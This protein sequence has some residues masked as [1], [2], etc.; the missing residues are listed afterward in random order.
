MKE[1]TVHHPLASLSDILGRDSS[2]FVSEVYGRR[3]LHL[4]KANA[5][6]F[7][8]LVTLDEIDN[9]L[10]SPSTRPP[11][12]RL[13]KQSRPT[14]PRNFTF[15]ATVARRQLDGLLDHA[16]VMNHFH[17]GYTVVLDSIEHWLPTV[18]SLLC[19][20][21]MELGA[22]GRA[23]VFASPPHEQALEPHADSYEIF[24]LQVSG[25]KKWSLY[26][27][28]DP[29]PRA[30]ARLNQDELGPKTESL[31]LNP[32]DVLYL[33]WGTPHVVE[34]LDSPSVHVSI[35]LRPP[36]WGEV[37]EELLRTVVNDGR[38][39]EPVL[40]HSGREDELSKQLST[41]LASI[42]DGVEAVSP[43]AY[44]KRLIATALESRRHSVG[45]TLA[46]LCAQSS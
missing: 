20:L 45:L 44:A 33:P 25:S 2:T 43:P 21:Q 23:A 10:A 46:S 12:I 6:A 41:R 40:M 4:P 24:V 3:P 42:M 14:D 30:G 11:Y 37:L 27:R 8:D 17:R 7:R 28:L 13:M 18:Q 36:T 34:S 35:G 39:H 32:G 19:S 1:N 22:G 31:V 29:V 15:S 38:E 9:I 16:L 26:E 5:T